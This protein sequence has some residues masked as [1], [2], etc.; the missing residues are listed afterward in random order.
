MLC[1][2]PKCIQLR[3]DLQEAWDRVLKLDQE[4]Q[5]MSKTVTEL[6]EA[7]RQLEHGV[8]YPRTKQ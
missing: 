4:L 7:V 6:Q 1:T 2:N 3:H 5:I 8:H